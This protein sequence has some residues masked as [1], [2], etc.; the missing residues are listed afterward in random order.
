MQMRSYYNSGITKP[1]AFR[2]EQ[3]INLKGALKKYEK[4]FH[5]ALYADLKK[6]PEECW[7]TERGCLLSEIN[8]ALKN[9]KE[10]MQAD[11]VATN[12]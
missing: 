6:S 1:Y 9:R 7:G 4:Q 5:E 10:W 11:L 3:L 12:L 2:K 8:G